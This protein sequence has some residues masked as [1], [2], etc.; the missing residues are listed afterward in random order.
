MLADA[1]IFEENSKKIGK[2]RI[3][4]KVI[5]NCAQLPPTSACLPKSKDCELEPWMIL[6]FLRKL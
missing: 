5:R 3:I 4:R 2:K 1:L 6:D